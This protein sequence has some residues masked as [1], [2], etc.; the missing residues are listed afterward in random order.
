[1]KFLS[2]FVIMIAT[3]ACARVH[4]IVCDRAPGTHEKMGTPKGVLPGVVTWAHRP[5][6]CTWS[7]NGDYWWRSRYVNQ[8]GVD[9]MLEKTLLGLTGAQDKIQAWD[10]LFRYFNKQVNNVDA[11][12]TEGEKITLKINLNNARDTNYYYQFGNG[13]SPQFLKSILRSLTRDVQVPQDLITVYDASRVFP[14]NLFEAPEGIHAEFAKVHIQDNVGKFGREK[15]EPDDLSTIQ[16]KFSNISVDNWDQTLLPKAITQAKYLIVVDNLRGHDLAG[17]TLSGKNFFGSMN[18]PCC[19]DPYCCANNGTEGACSSSFGRWCP[20]GMHF[21]ANVTA[22][23]MGSYTP[24]V[25][26]LGHE[27]LGGKGLLFLVDGLYG[28]PHEQE[29]VPVKFMS[30]PFN[31]HWSSSILAS[32]DPVALDSLAYDILRNE[33]NVPFAHKGCIDNYLHEAAEAEN[34][35]SKTMYKPG[36]KVLA[37]LGAHEHWVNFTYSGNRGEQGGIT[38]VKV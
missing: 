13:L 24:L 11:G 34:P 15:I 12:Y 1:M 33:P 19:P 4:D 36:N 25:D 38:L 37:S 9:E 10:K 28:G 3:V 14:P 35:V 29:V 22:R 30:E 21:W 5:E 7:G 27:E 17:V 2:L 16:L 26:L 18:R 32:V 8:Q 20:S 23:P 31:G 6:V